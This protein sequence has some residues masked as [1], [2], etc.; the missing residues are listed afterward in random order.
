ME[1]RSQGWLDAL[2]HAKVRELLCHALGRYG[3][4]CP[5]Y[6]LMPDHGHFLWIGLNEMSDQRLAAAAFREGWNFELRPGG[7]QLQRQP[8]DHVLREEERE[9]GAFAAVAQYIFENPVRAGLVEKWENYPFLGALVPGYP[10]LD[11]RE[12]DYWDRFW[13]IYGRLAGSV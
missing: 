10:I 11:P 13:R 9:R 4:V 12:E 1:S 5:A 8:F 2:H 7:R 6:C 3:V